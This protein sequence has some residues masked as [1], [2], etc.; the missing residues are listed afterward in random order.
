MAYRTLLTTLLPDPRA[1]HIMMNDA[2]ELEN[3]PKSH[4]AQWI[5]LRGKKSC[6]LL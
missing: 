1:L 5:N 6:F 3:G 2:S 4:E